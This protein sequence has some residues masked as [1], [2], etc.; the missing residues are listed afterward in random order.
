MWILCVCIKFLFSNFQLKLYGAWAETKTVF[1]LARTETKKSHGD[2]AFCIYNTKTK[3]WDK[4]IRANVNSYFG[5]VMDLWI[6]NVFQMNLIFFTSN[7]YFDIVQLFQTSCQ[8][9][10]KVI[11]F[12]MSFYTDVKLIPSTTASLLCY[13]E[14]QVL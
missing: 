11:Q 13:L 9:Q 1:F 14:L 10:D 7:N 12:C 6:F 5:F 3:I 4:P 8:S 2:Q